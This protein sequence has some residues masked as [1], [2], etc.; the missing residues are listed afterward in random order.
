[1]NQL[2][3][4]LNSNLPT[5]GA[6]DN[7]SK[8]LQALPLELLQHILVFT[9]NPVNVARIRAVSKGMKGIVDNLPD[10]LISR[11][12]TTQ[13]VLNKLEAGVIPTPTLSGRKSIARDS[14]SAHLLA[15]LATDPNIYVRRNLAANV[16][17]IGRQMKKNKR[18]AIDKNL[19]YCYF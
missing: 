14:K 13:L 16:T 6:P 5:I 17:R 2:S 19:P 11:I 18:G 3:N 1:M 9:Q 10:S 7:G 12:T 4:I 8:N 15:L